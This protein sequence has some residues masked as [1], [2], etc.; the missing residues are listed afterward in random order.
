M[1][2]NY[3]GHSAGFI[4]YCQLLSVIVSCALRRPF[5][6]DRVIRVSDRWGQMGTVCASIDIDH[7]YGSCTSLGRGRYVVISSKMPVSTTY[8][9]HCF[10]RTTPLLD[11]NVYVGPFCFQKRKYNNPN[12]NSFRFRTA[13]EPHLKCICKY[14][15]LI[16]FQNPDDRGTSHGYRLAAEHSR[17]RLR[18]EL[19][20]NWIND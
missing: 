12:Q 14:E 2:N 3:Y 20:F 6:H 4:S 17:N 8:E 16:P 9:R 11:Y 18:R 19:H 10:A 5:P 1:T 13:K 15:Q 7:N